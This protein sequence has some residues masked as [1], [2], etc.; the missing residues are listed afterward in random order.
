MF[1]ID[2]LS[3]DMLD[4][5]KKMY[6]KQM[7]AGKSRSLDELRL[8][9]GKDSRRMDVICVDVS[10]KEIPQIAALSSSA[11]SPLLRA[12]LERI[13]PTVDRWRGTL[14]TLLVFVS[15]LLLLGHKSVSKR[16][17]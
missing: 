7:A 1:D 11:W 4:I 6:D 2:A 14:D 15:S 12:H 10:H 5:L 9:H 8:R 17:R 13:Q 3:R 16:I